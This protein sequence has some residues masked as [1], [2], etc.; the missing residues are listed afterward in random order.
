MVTRPKRDLHWVTRRTPRCEAG[1]Y[2]RQP[3]DPLPA[4]TPP[5]NGAD[6]PRSIAAEG[7]AEP[8]TQPR[9]VPRRDPASSFMPSLPR[10]RASARRGSV[11][12]PY[13]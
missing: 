4:L 11:P 5:D 8:L 13:E 7:V 9:T 2:A 12:D 10:R 1:R 3:V 6:G